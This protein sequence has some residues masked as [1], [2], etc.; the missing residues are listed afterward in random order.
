VDWGSEP[1]ELAWIVR[2]RWWAARFLGSMSDG[3]RA[4]LGMALLAPVTFL[5]IFLV[6]TNVS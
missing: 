5:A 1:A 6:I 3:R 4:V 2:Y